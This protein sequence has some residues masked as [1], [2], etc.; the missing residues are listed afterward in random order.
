MFCAALDGNL[1]S[2]PAPRLTFST[3][4]H[5]F[6][7]S[8]P[9]ILHSVIQSTLFLPSPLSLSPS[10]HAPLF[11]P[12]LS[13]ISDSLPPPRPYLHL[14]SLPF[15]LS[16]TGNGFF[17]PIQGVGGP[18]RLSQTK[19]SLCESSKN[20]KKK[21]KAD[22][23]Q[24]PTLIRLPSYKHTLLPGADTGYFSAL[25]ILLTRYK[26]CRYSIGPRLCGAYSLVPGRSCTAA[27][28]AAPRRRKEKK[29]EGGRF[30]ELHANDM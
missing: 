28:I 30:D 23:H 26:Y 17:P 27:H 4:V 13:L 15:H 14:F 19:R 18:D 16:A 29:A 24:K 25:Y 9:R 8:S 12:F 6:T 22:K 2:R 21:R 7:H 3:G 11:F 10:F 20:T 5:S 1:I